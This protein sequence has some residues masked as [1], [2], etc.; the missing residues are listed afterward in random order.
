MGGPKRADR[1]LADSP[2]SRRFTITVAPLRR[3]HLPRR[4]APWEARSG[5]TAVSQIHQSLADSPQRSRRFGAPTLELIL[6]SYV[7]GPNRADRGLADSP[8]S[9]RF[10][11]TVAP[12]RRSHTGAEPRFP[13]RSPEAGRSAFVGGPSRADRGL[14]DSPKSRRFTPTVAPL[15]RSH[16]RAGALLPGFRSA[17]FARPRAIMVEPGWP[18]VH[19]LKSCHRARTDER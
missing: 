9:R 10:T 17:A 5:P 1:G 19:R 18:I 6:C 4:G 14:A 11:T 7:G 12:I 16:I 15:R 13:C 2:K 8:Q 3:S